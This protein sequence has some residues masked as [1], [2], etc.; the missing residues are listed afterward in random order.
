V[1]KRKA[2]DFDAVM[3]PVKEGATARNILQKRADDGVSDLT[4]AKTLRVDLIDPDPNQ[5]RKH[6]D[7]QALGE[8]AQSIRVQG[9][10]QPITVEWMP[11]TERFRLVF[12][13]RRWRA[14][15]RAAA[16]QEQE[17]EQGVEPAHLVARPLAYPCADPE[18]LHP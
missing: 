17:R 12:G 10:L 3:Q 1:A 11:Q 14:I 7:D 5:P 4:M 6:F 18:P 9:V 13:E 8:L 15:R 2:L 16:L